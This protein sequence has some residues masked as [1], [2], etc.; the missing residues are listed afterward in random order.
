MT[1]VKSLSPQSYRLR[2]GVDNFKIPIPILLGRWL[3]VNLSLHKIPLK[4]QVMTPQFELIRY[5]A[6]LS[7]LDSKPALILISPR[8]S[9]LIVRGNGK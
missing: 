4:F 7:H 8:F 3:F 5:W 9:S 1:R 6:P 2:G